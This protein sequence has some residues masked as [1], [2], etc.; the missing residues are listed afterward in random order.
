MLQAEGYGKT[1]EKAIENA[2]LELKASREDVDIK[3]INEGG[4]FKKAKVIVTIS[5]DAIDKY[6][7]RKENRKVEENVKEVI[8]E[9]S[10]EEKA[11][12]EIKKQEK[13]TVKKEKKEEKTEEKQIKKDEKQKEKKE[14]REN[15]YLDPK[16]FLTGLF[17]AMGKM[18]TISEVEDD[19]SIT[20]VVEGEDLGETIGYR[21][22]SFYAISNL[23]TT[24][25]KR[26]EK[27][28]FI[29]IDGYR[30]RREETLSATARRIANKVA[31]SGRFY[32]LEPMNPAER[33]IIH[34]AL[35]GDDRV[36]TLS[37]G[38][39]PHRYVIVFPKEYKE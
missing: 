10:V 30:A 2:L 1:I 7:K 21:G 37:K 26:G 8:S 23:L 15:K 34:T 35:Q 22:E 20:Y 9:N 29:D 33:R 36:T 32:K 4:L 28:I 6:Q 11:D 39:E 19:A 12:K 13:E 38:T 5:E 25:T 14:P 16:E 27:R 24:V 3:I 31:K 18:I 17:E